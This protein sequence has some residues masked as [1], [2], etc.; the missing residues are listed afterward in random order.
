MVAILN[1]KVTVYK[2]VPNK[3]DACVVCKKGNHKPNTIAQ[4]AMKS[5]ELSIKDFYCVFVRTELNLIAFL[6]P[7]NCVNKQYAALSGAMIYHMQYLSVSSMF[8]KVHF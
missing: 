8:V 2:I 4:Y 3:I 5:S 1:S 6:C 7:S